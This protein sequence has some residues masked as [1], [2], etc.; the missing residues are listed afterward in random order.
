MAQSLT[1]QILT[2]IV[3]LYLLAATCFNV[4]TTSPSP[5]PYSLPPGI[6]PSPPAPNGAPRFRPVYI[7]RSHRLQQYRA[8]HRHPKHWLPP[9]AS[10]NPPRSAGGDQLPT[11][12]LEVPHWSGPVASPRADADCIAARKKRK[13]AGGRAKIAHPYGNRHRY[14]NKSPVHEEHVEHIPACPKRAARGFVPRTIFSPQPQPLAPILPPTTPTWSSRPR[15]KSYEPA[16]PTPNI[17]K[18]YN[19]LRDARLRYTGHG[20]QKIATVNGI[21]RN[22]TYDRPLPRSIKL[23]T[24]GA[25]AGFCYT[26]SRIPG[27]NAMSNRHTTIMAVPAWHIYLAPH[28]MAIFFGIAV[29]AAVRLYNYCRL[30]YHLSRLPGSY[31]RAW[32]QTT[33]P[34]HVA[35]TCQRSYHNAAGIDVESPG[36]CAFAFIVTPTSCLLAVRGPAVSNPDSIGKWAMIGGKRDAEDKY[37][38]DTLIREIKEEVGFDISGLQYFAFSANSRDIGDPP[39]R[40]VLNNFI[41]YTDE[42]FRTHVP[43][44]ETEKVVNPTWHPRTAMASLDMTDECRLAW[45]QAQPFLPENRPAK[46]NQAATNDWIRRANSKESIPAGYRYIAINNKDDICMPY[47]INE[48]IKLWPDQATVERLFK[49]RCPPG[50]YSPDQCVDTT[51]YPVA[52]WDGDQC[53]WTHPATPSTRIWLCYSR[54][55][56]GRHVDAL[57]PLKEGEMIRDETVFPNARGLDQLPTNVLDLL[58]NPDGPS[59]NDNPPAPIPVERTTTQPPTPPV[60]P[61]N[62]IPQFQAPDAVSRQNSM[63]PKPFERAAT[64]IRGVGEIASIFKKAAT[65]IVANDLGTHY[66]RFNNTLATTA[67]D[68]RDYVVTFDSREALFSEVSHEMQAKFGIPRDPIQA[69]VNLLYSNNINDE[70]LVTPYPHAATIEVNASISSGD[71]N[72][73]RATHLLNTLRGSTWHTSNMLA[74]T[75]SANYPE[76][77]SSL[78]NDITAVFPHLAMAANVAARV[79]NFVT[80]QDDVPG[81]TYVHWYERLIAGW[82]MTTYGPTVRRGADDLWIANANLLFPDAATWDYLNQ[83]SLPIPAYLAGAPRLESPN[84]MSTYSI[85][86]SRRATAFQTPAPSPGADFRAVLARFHYP[87]LGIVPGPTVVTPAGQQQ[88]RRRYSVFNSSFIETL[89]PVV[90]LQATRFSG[91]RDPL[92]ANAYTNPDSWRDAIAFL[93]NNFGHSADFIVALQNTFRRSASFFPTEISELPTRPFERLTNGQEVEDKTIRRILALRIIRPNFDNDHDAGARGSMD[94]LNSIRIWNALPPRGQNIAG[95]NAIPHLA[96]INQSFPPRARW[97]NVNCTPYQPIEATLQ[98]EGA[99]ATVQ[100]SAVWAQFFAGTHLALAGEPEIRMVLR[101][102][103]TAELN[104]LT[105]WLEQDFFAVF[106]T[107]EPELLPENGLP[108]VPAITLPGQAE[109]YN[110]TLATFTGAA[111]PGN[112]TTPRDLVAAGRFYRRDHCMTVHNMVE[113]YKFAVP[114]GCSA[115][116]DVRMSANYNDD[117]AAIQLAAR[118]RHLGGHG[119]L[120]RFAC[121]TSQWRAA[122]DTAACALSMNAANINHRLGVPNTGAPD[123]DAQLYRT[124]DRA[125]LGGMNNLM[126]TYISVVSTAWATL[127]YASSLQLEYRGGYTQHTLLPVTSFLDHRQTVPD[128][129]DTSL[130]MS[131]HLLWRCFHPITVGLLAPLLPLNGGLVAKEVPFMGSISSAVTLPWDAW[132]IKFTAIFDLAGWLRVMLLSAGYTI[133]FRPSYVFAPGR[134]SP[135]QTIVRV[136][137]DLDDVPPRLSDTAPWTTTL[138]QD[139]YWYYETP[140]PI[141]VVLDTPAFINRRAPFLRNTRLVAH[142]HSETLTSLPVLLPYEAAAP[143]SRNVNRGQDALL[144]GAFPN[145]NANVGPRRFRINMPGM[146]A[147]ANNRYHAADGSPTELHLRSIEYFSRMMSNNVVYMRSLRGLSGNG[148]NARRTFNATGNA[149]TGPNGVA[150][151]ANYAV[152]PCEGILLT[153]GSC[154]VTGTFW[155]DALPGMPPALPLDQEDSTDNPHL[156]TF[157]TI[158]ATMQ[159]R[160]RQWYFRATAETPPILL[161]DMTNGLVPSITHAFDPSANDENGAPALVSNRFYNAAAQA[162][163]AVDQGST[164]DPVS[165]ELALAQPAIL[166]EGY[167]TEV[168]NEEVSFHAPRLVPIQTGTHQHF[169]SGMSALVKAPITAPSTGLHMVPPILADKQPTRNDILREEVERLE[170]LTQLADVKRRLGLEPRIQEA[171]ETQ[172]VPGPAQ[173]HSYT[174]PMVTETK[175]EYHH[176]T[177]G[178]LR[179]SQYGT[180]SRQDFH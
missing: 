84:G 77:A 33:P 37:M 1:P 106:G 135:Q 9:P 154:W 31:H 170:L 49:A 167:N 112:T 80:T 120:V 48:C 61:I 79:V 134:S 73:H 30:A 93:L 145:Y 7:S 140:R 22:S 130:T 36:Q 38:E 14:S 103:T 156:R 179:R 129:Q 124:M 52:C 101:T 177:R 162:M 45:D 75:R 32:L 131:S 127:G 91:D 64:A 158:W 97:N 172:N 143:M 89:P 24:F 70:I 26:F 50:G 149:I 27:A 142:Y 66:Y 98:R 58:A 68:I 171:G 155:R 108:G 41:V 72:R 83:G 2:I 6:P 60:P 121:I 40:I 65:A 164:L 144:F 55:G 148:G 117:T 62:D 137:E 81:A 126:D 12:K 165:K 123:M 78:K 151:T 99:S 21:T 57:I 34:I 85:I 69:L 28:I 176:G 25:M 146:L 19:V 119:L 92:P 94:W 51:T 116:R 16:P 39:Q 133:M 166:Q 111:L 63:S 53:R 159:A 105:L 18:N 110:L 100:S 102:M 109:D 96:A 178:L 56:R 23:D 138:A 42:E 95:N 132:L 87:H 13:A 180:P 157:Y 20:F 150:I 104:A 122:T 115:M 141:K 35:Q 90:I 88:D 163:S 136:W 147:T 74:N 3:Y 86:P 44:A 82:L 169:V 46:A 5:T 160:H 139:P 114:I 43:P 76:R 29:W 153:N 175:H 15:P 118:L 107:L 10:K 161:G 54:N 17:V 67:T 4:A 125:T 59:H 128:V 8:T 113:S 11:F 168:R 152:A 174:L 47:A 173:G 71:A